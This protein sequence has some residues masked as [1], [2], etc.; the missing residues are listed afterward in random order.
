ARAEALEIV[1][2]NPSLLYGGLSRVLNENKGKNINTF[3]LYPEK[4]RGF[5]EWLIQLYNESLGKPGVSLLTMAKHGLRNIV[6]AMPKISTTGR[7]MV[8]TI[9][10]EDDPALN[11]PVSQ[12]AGLYKR[13]VENNLSE[14]NNPLFNIQL[15]KLDEAAIA[16]LALF[17]FGAVVVEAKSFKKAKDVNAYGEPGVLGSKRAT[18]KQLRDERLAQE[19]LKAGKSAADKTVSSESIIDLG[20]VV[21]GIDENLKSLIESMVTKLWPSLSEEIQFGGY[22]RPDLREQALT[23]IINEALKGNPLVD[24]IWVRNNDKQE[25]L[26]HAKGKYL[27]AVTPMENPACIEQ[28][29]VSAGSLFGIYEGN[30]ASPDKLVA[31]FILLK[32]PGSN[33]I[34]FVQGRQADQVIN[35]VFDFK[36][37]DQGRLE[38]RENPSRSDIQAFIEAKFSGSRSALHGK[39]SDWLPAFKAFKRDVWNKRPLA[40]RYSNSLADLYEILLNGGLWNEV[41][42]PLEAMEVGAIFEYAGGYGR[43][44]IMTEEGPVSAGRI[45]L[46]QYKSCYDPQT[47]QISAFF[48]SK[49]IIDILEAYLVFLGT[50]L[51]LNNFAQHLVACIND[52]H[53]KNDVEMQK[54]LFMFSSKIRDALE[55]GKEINPALIA[56]VKEILSGGFGENVEQGLVDAL[57]PSLEKALSNLKEAKGKAVSNSLKKLDLTEYAVLGSPELLG[58]VR[59]A[60]RLRPS[61]EERVLAKLSDEFLR[62]NTIQLI[63]SLEKKMD[64]F[65]VLKIITGDIAAL[66]KFYKANTKTYQ[67]AGWRRPE[68]GENDEI[69]LRSSEGKQTFDQDLAARDK[70]KPYADDVAEILTSL[71]DVTVK[72]AIPAFLGEDVGFLLGETNKSGDEVADLDIVFNDI[73]LP[74]IFNTG[75]VKEIISEEVPVGIAKEFKNIEGKISR[76]N[77]HSH[78]RVLIDP[79][80][81]SSKV[82]TN[83][84]VGMIMGIEAD[85]VMI[86]SIIVLFG[87]QTS[88]IFASEFTEGVWEYRLSKDGK[89]VKVAPF[90]VPQCAGKDSTGLAL[91]GKRSKWAPDEVEEYISYLETDMGGYSTY[92]G[93]YVSDLL[94]TVVDGGMYIYPALKDGKTKGRLRPYETRPVGYI[95]EKAGGYASTGFIRIMDIALDPGLPKF[96]HQI[97]PV[98]V[99]SEDLVKEF[100]AY[101]T[102]KT[103]ERL[104]Q[105]MTK[106]GELTAEDIH[107]LISDGHLTVR[108]KAAE[109]KLYK[110][111]S[112]LRRGPADNLFHPE[113]REALT[114]QMVE[115]FRFHNRR[116]EAGI[117]QILTNYRRHGR[118]ILPIHMPAET[119]I[120]DDLFSEILND[121]ENDHLLVFPEG[122]HV[123]L[124]VNAA[125]PEA[126]EKARESGRRARGDAVSLGEPSAADGEAARDQ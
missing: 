121:I 118:I 3:L 84:T 62:I 37:N 63:K 95:F 87:A 45:D 125:V 6:S 11:S 56:E 70:T 44:L 65:P 101:V 110:Y 106:D 1:K 18:L 76:G 59:K 75:K 74:V 25:E 32:G 90:V 86:A 22:G 29:N 52:P 80:D 113:E 126:V 58:K 71:L 117:N 28:A 17:F 69:T 91:G 8:T 7:T 93:S 124:I 60:L 48:G 16:D 123:R 9:D 36:L 51:D 103:A 54:I 100:E 77:Q 2:Q 61:V 66:R 27:V 122:D 99:G 21:P 42:T 88:L 24:S 107:A 111:T 55:K 23:N 92:S 120:S 115:L 97:E 83:G 104:L 5:R 30:K 12:T 13:A 38:P 64:T 112:H 116:V 34:G 49:E 53:I 46:E 67:N 73:M 40:V 114:S 39:E 78:L 96:P 26:L 10:V 72:R 41:L 57:L 102:N 15:P 82:A 98:A 109:N 35:N 105:Q 47:Q 14:R 43:S 81:G 79:L 19:R 89:F 4:L 68:Q 119:E 31:S 33:F 85:G 108:F 94:R 20:S 50:G